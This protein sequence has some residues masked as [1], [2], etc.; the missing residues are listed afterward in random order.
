MPQPDKPCESRKTRS[1]GARDQDPRKTGEAGRRL[2]FGKPGS[3]DVSAGNLANKQ[4]YRNARLSTLPTLVF[5]SSVLN[6]TCLGTL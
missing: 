2:L 1:T 6:S 5:G 3:P 4:N